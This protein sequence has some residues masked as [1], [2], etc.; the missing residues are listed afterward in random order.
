[1]PV[2]E[3][4]K[5]PSLFTSTAYR[6]CVKCV[7][8]D[9]SLWLSQTAR[10]KIIKVLPYTPMNKMC[11]VNQGALRLDGELKA[12]SHMQHESCKPRETLKLYL[13]NT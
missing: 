4:N 9:D 3:K 1:L 13:F 6:S 12:I 2:V 5:G 8:D 10:V 7:R 11:F